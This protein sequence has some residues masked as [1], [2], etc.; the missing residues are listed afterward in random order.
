MCGVSLRSN[1]TPILFAT[2]WA[3]LMTAINRS[4]WFGCVILVGALYGF[5]GIVFALPSSHARFW[6]LAAWVVS[7]VVYVSHLA[8]EQF[9]LRNSPVATAVHAATAA[10]LGGFLLAVG[11]MVHAT[12]TPTHAPYW[13]HGIALIVWPI[14]TAAPALFIA[15]VVTHAYNRMK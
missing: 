12:M 10:A 13:L 4:A 5:I 6:R 1:G 8:Y 3:T 9:W 7:G 15:L 2:R 11:A 14:I